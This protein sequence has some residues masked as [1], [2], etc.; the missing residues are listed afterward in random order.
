MVV[1]KKLN[2]IF[3]YKKYK[4]ESFPFWTARLTN[5]FILC[6]CCGSGSGPG[7]VK[8]MFLRLY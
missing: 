4:S 5:I 7:S 3:K 1:D 8:S 2:E 6:Q